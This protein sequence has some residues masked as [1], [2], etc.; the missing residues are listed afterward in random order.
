MPTLTYLEAISLALR[1]EMREDPRVFLIGEDIGGYG[2]AFKV[3][4]GFLEDF[5]ESRVVDTPIAES[6]IAGVS[7]GA[8]IR[9]MRPV[10]EMQFADFITCA[11][12]QL[13]TYASMNYY[14]T[15]IPLPMTVRLPYGGGLTAGPFHSKCP[16]GWFYHIPGLKLV[17]PS[18][19]RD[20][21]GLLKAAIRD[22]NP[23]LYFEHKYLYRRMKE[24]VPEH[25]EIVPLGKGIVRREGRH[26]TVITYG[27]AVQASLEAAAALAKDGI[28]SEVVDMR[29]LLPYDRALLLE[30]AKKTGKVLIVHEA[31]KTGGI[32]GDWAATIA[33]EAF[34]HLDA[35]VR[36]L[37]ALD[38][39]VPF[40]P[41]L[42]PRYLPN[43][44]KIEAALRE[45]AAY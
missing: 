11:F 18:T 43:A 19:P 29:T 38:T 23:V 13:A 25:D 21:R 24:D 2:G 27:A 3:T 10:A 31:T 5:G 15:G 45:L 32:G 35:P 42:E 22:P 1:E 39:P 8:A 30:S 9:G 34:E 4:K 33:E 12:N 14:R 36:R 17:A 41:V 44:K 28:E 16:E 40:S 6:M 37:A 26:L 7:I 20:A